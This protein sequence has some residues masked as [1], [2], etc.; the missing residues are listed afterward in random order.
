MTH[1][2]KKL[3]AALNPDAIHKMP[4]KA[5]TRMLTKMKVAFQVGWLDACT[6]AM[7]PTGYF[8]HAG[9]VCFVLDVCLDAWMHECMGVCAPV[10]FG[11]VAHA[12]CSQK[13]VER[14]TL[15]KLALQAVEA[16]S[17]SGPKGIIPVVAHSKRSTKYDL[18][19]NI[20]HDSPPVKARATTKKNNPLSEGTY[21]VHVNNPVRP[22]RPVV[23]IVLVRVTC[24]VRGA[25]LPINGMKCRTCT[26]KKQCRS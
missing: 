16:R 4:V 19:A 24:R 12:G 13:P 5:L 18:L 26:F 11:C 22:P 7:L 15:V 8:S 9:L 21:R 1:K 3:P 25:R 17:C 10:V 23:L 2:G 14:E 6:F 20:V